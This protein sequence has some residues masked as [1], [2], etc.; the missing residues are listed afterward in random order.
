MCVCVLVRDLHFEILLGFLKITIASWVCS[1]TNGSFFV[2]PTVCVLAPFFFPLNADKRYHAHREFADRRQNVNSAR[3]YFYLNEAQCEK[4][5]DIFLRC[6]EAVSGMIIYLLYYHLFDW[7]AFFIS[8]SR[9]HQEHGLCGHQNDRTGSSP[10]ISKTTLNR[11][12][13]RMAI[14]KK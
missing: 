13:N 14:F 7:W 6:I 8:Y 10:I 12:R 1:F 9:N 4:N 11:T 3:T 5:V 2:P